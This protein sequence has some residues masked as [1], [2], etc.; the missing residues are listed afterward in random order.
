MTEESRFAEYLTPE[1]EI[2]SQAG[3]GVT[4]SLN[5]T[6]IMFKQLS[7]PMV[8][9]IYIGD[10]TQPIGTI[11]VAKGATATL[12]GAK[13]H[14]S[15]DVSN[16]IKGIEEIKSELEGLEHRLNPE[17]TVRPQTILTHPGEDRFGV[18]CTCH[19]KWFPH[20]GADYSTIR[21]DPNCPYCGQDWRDLDGA[22]DY[23]DDEGNP[24]FK[25]DEEGIY[26]HAKVPEQ[27]PRE[28]R[29]G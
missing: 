15:S 25:R 12:G 9:E 29:T 17:G 20:K 24:A 2:T 22:E 8:Y 5:G 13:E 28:D 1:A 7:V 23:V 16:Y 11:N 14:L 18:V 26:E 27:E 10:E 21:N 3:D 19:N 6:Q 4:V